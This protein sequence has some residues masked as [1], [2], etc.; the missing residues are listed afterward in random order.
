MN[1]PGTIEITG[2]PSVQTL[3]A[4]SLTEGWNLIGYPCTGE[5][6]FAPTPIS[7]YFDETN[8]QIIKNFD[9]FWMPNEPTSSL[10]TF[11]LGKGYFILA[12]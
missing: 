5:S 7:D 12:Q 1:T 11:E 6:L 9:G 3:H 2:I 10:N 4:T 8:C